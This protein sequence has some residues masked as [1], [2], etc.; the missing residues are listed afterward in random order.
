V[1]QFEI[2]APCLILPAVLAP[3]RRRATTVDVLPEHRANM[4]MAVRAAMVRSEV[5][6]RISERTKAGMLAASDGAARALREAW[7]LVTPQVRRQFL[8]V[9]LAPACHVSGDADA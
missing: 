7:R 2:R 8:A 4:V 3:R 9:V 5:R 6:A 1:S